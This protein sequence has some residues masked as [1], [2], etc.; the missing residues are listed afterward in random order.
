[1]NRIKELIEQVGT[2][3]SGKWMRI[4]QAELLAELIIR[5]C[6]N[7]AWKCG[8]E[9]ID[10]EIKKHFGVQVNEEQAI[11]FVMDFYQVSRDVAC[12]LYKDEIEAYMKLI[13]GVEN[14]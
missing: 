14:G 7:V 1:M 6:G 3:S 4:D 10:N 5:E 9:F 8:S 2:D 13:S 11:L 12:E